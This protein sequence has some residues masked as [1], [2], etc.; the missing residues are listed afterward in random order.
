[1]D[2]ARNNC[3]ASIARTSRCGQVAAPKE[4]SRSA[5]GR[6]ALAVVAPR[7]EP[8]R[9]LSGG[10]RL[11]ALIHRDRYAVARKRRDVAALVRKLGHLGRPGDT[12]QIA[13]DQLGLRRAADLPARN[14]V[15]EHLLCGERRAERPG[16]DRPE[17]VVNGAR[18]L[19]D[20]ARTVVAAAGEDRHGDT[21]AVGKSD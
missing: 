16:E 17:T 20:G 21:A 13:F 3:S 2:V 7:L 14:D 11:A 6:L 10:Q 1:M 9:K 8:F 5:E 12:L 19:G 4:S 15:E 18:G